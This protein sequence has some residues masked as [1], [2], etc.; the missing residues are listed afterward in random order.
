MIDLHSHLLPGIDDGATD[1]QTALVMAQCYVDDGV[2]TV[3]C[4]PHILPGVYHNTG[5]QIRTAVQALQAELTNRGINLTLVPGCDGHVVPDFVAGIKSGRLLTLNDSRYVLVEPPHNV[6]PPRLEEMFF[7]VMVA[8]YVPILTHPERLTWIAHQYDKMR[9]LAHG[10]VWMQ[11]TAGSLIGDFGRQP[12]YWAERMLDEGL[13]HV[14]ATDA[15]DPVRRA[16]VLSRGYDAA[17]TRIGGDAAWDLVAIRPAGVLNDISASEL[18]YPVGVSA[19]IGNE[20]S[21]ARD[22]ADAGGPRDGGRRG[23]SRTDRVSRASGRRW[24]DRL[25]GLFE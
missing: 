13:V 24:T 18:P 3:A 21:L 16:P 5:P 2:T 20:W 22:E 11:I 25:R 10:G 15:H 4:T 17:A 23:D 14:L 7:G 19:G 1:L 8:G 9:A 6:P 12:K